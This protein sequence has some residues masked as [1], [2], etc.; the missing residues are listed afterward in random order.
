MIR[1]D[2]MTEEEIKVICKFFVDNGKRNFT[3]AERELIKQA[4]DQSRNWQEL[5]A[6]AIASSMRR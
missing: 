1:K 2:K 6:V 4:I 5:L 3:D